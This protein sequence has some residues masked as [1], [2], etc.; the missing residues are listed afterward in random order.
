MRGYDY[1]RSGVYFVTICTNKRMKLF[2]AIVDG[3]SALNFLGTIACEEWRRIAQKR[4]NVEL[5]HYVI[6]P[7]HVHGLLV[8]TDGLEGDVDQSP[9]SRR[10]E[11]SRGI[12]VGSL[13]A[14]IS[15]YKAAVR[16]W[17]VCQLGQAV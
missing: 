12:P 4:K 14:I 16:G 13:G 9:K 3:E 8:I 2:G 5:D 10:P 15:Q 11:T 17:F 6:M 1:R 7:N